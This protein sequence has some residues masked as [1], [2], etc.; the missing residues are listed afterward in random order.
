M[1]LR[2]DIIGNAIGVEPAHGWFVIE[3][4]QFGKWRPLF[5]LTSPD[6]QDSDRAM[7]SR[8]SKLD[9]AVGVVSPGRR[10]KTGRSAVEGNHDF[11]VNIGA[12]IVVVVKFRSRHS[13]SYKYRGSFG[14]RI[15]TQRIADHHEILGHYQLLLGGVA[16]DGQGA[17][18]RQQFALAKMYVLE[19]ASGVPGRLQ[20]HPLKLGAHIVGGKLESAGASA[21]PLEKVVG[22]KRHVSP[23]SFRPDL[24]QEFLR[25]KSR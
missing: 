12:G 5:H 24:L 17:L 19:I 4:D 13:E 6:N 25:R 10:G 18:L 9:D 22:Q 11:S 1:N 14:I 7:S 23:N 3:T 21:A 20:T 15:R 2:L 8:V 16:A